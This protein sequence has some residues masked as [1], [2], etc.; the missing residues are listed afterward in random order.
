MAGLELS[1]LD[2][3]RTIMNRKAPSWLNTYATKT[4]S[5]FGYDRTAPALQE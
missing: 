4:L 2:G 5:E 1:Y 3:V